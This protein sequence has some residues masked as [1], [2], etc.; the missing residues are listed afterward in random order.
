MIKKN[1]III[2]A[3]IGGLATA[4]LLAKDGH[5]VTIL[6]KNNA[7][8][9]RA[10]VWKTKGFTFDM[11]PSWYMMPDAF[12]HYFS[13]F[14]KKPSDYYEL[15]RL[16]PRYTV[17]F[18]DKRKYTLS[19]S[20]KEN[21]KLFDT[22]ETNGGEKLSQFLKQSEE[23]YRSAMNE[24]VRVDYTSLGHILSPKLLKMIFRMKLFTSY[25][26]DVSSLFKNH[27]L[28]KILE[29]PTVFLGGS[30]YITPAFYTLIAHTDFNLNIWHP[31]G[32]IYKV[33]KAF[34]TLCK[35]YNVSILTDHE[36][37]R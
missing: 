28:Q 30:P 36:C 11:G 24:L 16:N 32:G 25:H 37:R 14:N 9:G 33:I 19:S 34:E 22:L 5:S 23:F 29:F 26:S 27:D 12:E 3:G 4:A 6:E 1:I 18:D 21:K 10:S 13:L 17:F 2:G 20:L 15:V 7:I 35:E 8:G 31:L